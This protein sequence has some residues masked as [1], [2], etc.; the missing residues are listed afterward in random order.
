MYLDKTLL[1]KGLL[2]DFHTGKYAHFNTISL[3]QVDNPHLVNN[4][5][6]ELDLWK[7]IRDIAC[8]ELKK[9]EVTLF[10][11][12]MML[13]RSKDINSRVLWHQD[14]AFWKGYHGL[15][16]AVSVLV[17]TISTSK[18]NGGLKYL[19]TFYKNLL[20]HKLKKKNGMN[21][22]IE[23]S[24]EVEDREGMDCKTELGD[25]VI[26][27]PTSVHM[28]YPNLSEKDRNIFVAIFM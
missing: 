4:C 6:L 8:A 24:K 25:V 16:T 19:K 21:L 15:K 22:F 7:V 13:K 26:H 12:H 9:E 2:K 18:S 1:K 20:P 14:I 17:P 28:S 27:Y 23:I 11:T 10:A 5:L 3:P